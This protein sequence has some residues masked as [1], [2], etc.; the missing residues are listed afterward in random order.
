MKKL[1]TMGILISSIISFSNAPSPTINQEVTG[2]NLQQLEYKKIVN[3]NDLLKNQNIE[4]TNMEIVGDLLKRQKQ[5]IKIIQSDSI[6]LE[7]E[8]VK[9][10]SKGFFGSLFN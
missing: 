2:R 5:R 4:S 1:V 6:Q 9:G 10:K 8:I 7:E 3:T